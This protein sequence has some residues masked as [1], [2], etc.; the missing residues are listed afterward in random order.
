MCL[1]N[2]NRLTSDYYKHVSV[3]SYVKPMSIFLTNERRRINLWELKSPMR[4]S[5]IE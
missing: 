3:C 5:V 2:H 4:L 1:V